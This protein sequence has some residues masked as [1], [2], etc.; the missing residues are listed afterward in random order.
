MST[1]DDLT[2]TRALRK[3]HGPGNGEAAPAV[4]YTRAAYRENWDALLALTRGLDAI[5]NDLTSVA[6]WLSSTPRVPSNGTLPRTGVAT[7]RCPR[8][9]EVPSG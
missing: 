3:L 9:Y 4:A 6:V 8:A 2:A 7:T 1:A 5:D